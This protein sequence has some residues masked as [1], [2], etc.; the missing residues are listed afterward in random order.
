MLEETG[1]ALVPGVAFGDD[2]FVRMS[3]A[4]DD[5]TLKLGIE[6][7]DAFEELLGEVIDV[8][9]HGEVIAKECENQGG[10]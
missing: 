5:A 8:R 3:F 7:K 1:V 4:T 2:R 10:Y 9:Q 6:R